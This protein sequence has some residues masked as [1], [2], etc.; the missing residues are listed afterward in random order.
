MIEVQ[1]YSRWRAPFIARS[2]VELVERNKR[3]LDDFRP[4][5]SAGYGNYLGAVKRIS[6]IGQSEDL[7]GY[8]I[9]KDQAAIG[10]AT[11]IKDRRIEVATKKGVQQ[12]TGFDMDYWLD[13]EANVSLSVAY[14]GPMIVNALMKAEGISKP[15]TVIFAALQP[16]ELRRAPGIAEVLVTVGGVAPI[17]VPEPDPYDIAKGGVDLQVYASRN[18]RQ[19]PQ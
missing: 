12:L 15:G 18:Y 7:H 10:I 2:A 6:R 4:G 13:L 1:K 19:I 9:R 5:V 11:L 17:T 3:W 8:L 14:E 16:E